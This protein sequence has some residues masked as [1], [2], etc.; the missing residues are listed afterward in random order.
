MHRLTAFLL[1]ACALSFVPALPAQAQA[2]HALDRVL[3]GGALERLVTGMLARLDVDA[4]IAGF[5]RTAEAA[6]QGRAVDPAEFDQL[7]RHLDRQL[8]ESAPHLARGAV[9]L[10]GPVLRELRAELGR[11]LASTE[12]D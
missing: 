9:G 2:D 1:T 5:E 4:L 10:L 11:E 3:A 6:A 7:G 12:G 8:A